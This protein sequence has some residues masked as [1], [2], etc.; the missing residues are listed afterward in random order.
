MGRGGEGGTGGR[1]DGE[2][3]GRELDSLGFGVLE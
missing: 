2:M 3:G 1:G